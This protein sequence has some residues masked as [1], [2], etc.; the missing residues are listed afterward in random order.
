MVINT[1]HSQLKLHGGLKMYSEFPS[2][3]L[4]KESD[5]CNAT[6]HAHMWETKRPVRSQ[7]QIPQKWNRNLTF[8][9]KHSD[10]KRKQKVEKGH[11]MWRRIYFCSPQARRPERVDKSQIL[12]NQIDVFLTASC[13]H[14]ER[15]RSVCV[16]TQTSP[17]KFYTYIPER[18]ST[19]ETIILST[20][21]VD[22]DSSARKLFRT[23]PCYLFRLKAVAIYVATV[24]TAL[25]L[26]LTQ[27]S[28]P[29]SCLT[30]TVSDYIQFTTYNFRD[31]HLEHFSHF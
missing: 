2:L 28:H 8:N 12:G 7:L 22:Q 11:H 27:F 1:D 10:G 16:I 18:F 21:S 3:F 4:F 30:S 5:V 24:T 31:S 6:P 23:T 15:Q 20:K 26:L 17:T 25:E 9:T 14:F 19:H 29:L 13:A